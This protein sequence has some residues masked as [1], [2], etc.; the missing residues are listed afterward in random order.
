MITMMMIMIMMS[1]SSSIGSNAV[2]LQHERCR[3][4]SRRLAGGKSAQCTLGCMQLG[5]GAAHSNVTGGCGVQPSVLQ[6]MSCSLVTQLTAVCST[7]QLHSS[8]AAE[9]H[10]KTQRHN[11]HPEFASSQFSQHPLKGRPSHTQSHPCRQ[12]CCRHVT[13]CVLVTVHC[14][15]AHYWRC[16][17]QLLT[18]LASLC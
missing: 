3:D 13:Q 8:T 10:K 16:C 18:N 7:R 1:S 15:T 4:A 2:L 9:K 5:S 6:H 12:L 11:S 14:N 17:I